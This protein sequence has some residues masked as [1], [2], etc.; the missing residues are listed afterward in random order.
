MPPPNSE[1]HSSTEPG[2]PF[3]KENGDLGLAWVA[4]EAQSIPFLPLL[5]QVDTSV[6]ETANGLQAAL[7]KR[8]THHQKSLSEQLLGQSW[9]NAGPGERT[10]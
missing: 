1:P 9:A 7:V 6:H 5:G 4:W 10:D 2:L 3:Q 8:P